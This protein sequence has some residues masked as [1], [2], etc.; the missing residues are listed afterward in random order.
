MAAAAVSGRPVSVLVPPWARTPPAADAAARFAA[1]S[2]MDETLRIPASSPLAMTAGPGAPLGRFR[3]GDLIHRLLERLPD[4]PSPER[5]DAA[6]R[7]L[8]RERDLDDSQREEMIA[9]A[10]A[11]LH[12]AGFA[13]VFGPGSRPEVALTGSVG[14]I[15]VSGRMDRLVVTPDR[16]LV[17]DYKTNRPAPARIEDADP[18]YVLQLAVYVSILRD[19][20]PDR[21]VDAAMVWTDG[22][23]LMAVPRAMMEAAL[24]G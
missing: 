8:S 19:L 11:V 6:R 24:S 17:V 22:P 5:A 13:P 14:A 7:M 16:V 1:P 12:D 15:P 3:R 4:I 9:A 10:F 18:A 23:R 21:R 2:R 20:Y